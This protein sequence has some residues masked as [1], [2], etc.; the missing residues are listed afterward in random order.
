MLLE[1]TG[2]PHPKTPPSR[3]C[4]GKPC[5]PTR[6]FQIGTK[7]N[8]TTLCNRTAGGGNPSRPTVILSERLLGAPLLG[9]V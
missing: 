9:S 4:P 3:L 7:G 6:G 5:A 1:W 2:P 8:R